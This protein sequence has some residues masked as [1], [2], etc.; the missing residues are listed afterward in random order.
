MLA[1]VLEDFSRRK[2]KCSILTF[3]WIIMYINNGPDR[4]YA[5]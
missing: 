4:G 2:R 1:I 5:Q 3:C